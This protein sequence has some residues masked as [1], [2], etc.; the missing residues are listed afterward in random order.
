MAAEA[1]QFDAVVLNA[2][3]HYAP[4]VART[5]EAAHALVATGGTLVVMDSPWFERDADGEVMVT[6]QLAEFTRRYGVGEVVRPGLGYLTFRRL[7]DVAVRLGRRTYFTQSAGPVGWRLK[8]CVR[9]R[10]ASRPPA[11]FGV[12]MTQ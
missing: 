11:T 8:R 7:Q 2:S 5:L 6:E 10:H 1:R 4:D 12:W 3:L 9:R